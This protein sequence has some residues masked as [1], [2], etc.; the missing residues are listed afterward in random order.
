MLSHIQDANVLWVRGSWGSEVCGPVLM[1]GRTASGGDK[2]LVSPV[3]RQPRPWLLE[4]Q[5][6]LPSSLSWGGCIRMCGLRSSSVS[7][8]PP[9]IS[10]SHGVSYLHTLTQQ[11]CIFVCVPPPLLGL[12]GAV[13]YLIVLCY[14]SSSWRPSVSVYFTLNFY[15]HP[16]PLF[17]QFLFSLIFNLAFTPS[18]LQQ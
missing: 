10:G 1:L 6:G 16:F 7:G 18:L 17:F 15:L 2:R 14:R 5:L 12:F 11:N 9:S 4:L 13:Y 3:L 8:R